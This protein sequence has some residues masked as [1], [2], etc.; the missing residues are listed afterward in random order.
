[1]MLI[2]TGVTHFHEGTY[3]FT[4]ETHFYERTGFYGVDSFQGRELMNELPVI[5]SL[6]LRKDLRHIFRHRNL[7]I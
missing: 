1:M 4:E 2:L 3:F 7:F 5:E 6:C